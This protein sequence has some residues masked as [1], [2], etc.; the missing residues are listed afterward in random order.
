MHRFIAADVGLRGLV[1]GVQL[2]LALELPL[3]R[4][5]DHRRGKVAVIVLASIHERALRRYKIANGKRAEVLRRSATRLFRPE[6]AAFLPTGKRRF[7]RGEFWDMTVPMLMMPPP[8]T[9]TRFSDWPFAV[10]LI[11]GFW[12]FYAATVVIRAFLGADPWTMLE[13]KLLVV[14][15]GI[16]IN[17]FIYLAISPFTT[18][19]SIRR[20][21][22]VAGISAAVGSLV[23]GGTVVAT[24][25]L[26][27][28]SREEFRFQAREGF[29]VVEQGNQIRIERTAGEPLVLTMPKVHE[30][31][32]MKRV[33]Y[34]LDASIT[35][36]FFYI[37][38]SAFYI[39]NQAQAEVL[40]TQRRLAV[41]ESA[42]QAAQVR[43][44]RY[45]VNPH[46]LF[47]TLNSLSSLVM[48]GRSDRAENMLLALSTFFRTSLSLDPGADVTLAEEIALQRLY[49]DIE[50]A[51]FPD[52][53]QVE[54]AVP[55][56][57]EQARLP[58]LL[59]QPIVENA[60][61][62]GVSKS[63]KA[64]IMRIEAR[65]LDNHRMVVEISNQL[66]NGGKDELPAATHE[67]TGLG[68]TNVCQRLEARFGDHA[69]CR[70]G[71]MHGG[72][73]KVSLTMPVVLNAR[74]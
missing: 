70:F 18:G 60:I 63:R 35:W 9:R 57:L 25:D 72:G 44:L 11:L 50:K 67:G 52:R 47:N 13:N 37:G 16:V 32:L 30:L 46:F 6:A 17:V 2:Q 45:Q 14:G 64:V 51:R 48:T 62:Y 19:S 31:D 42:A 15:I 56:D 27:R 28:E 59:L 68:L 39:A 7:S 36:L 23:L 8:V 34:A 24:E 40:G 21:A 12:L 22:I 29:T 41:A 69:N 61:K 1:A 43:A 4:R 73:F 20:K 10:K 33:R 49:L 26:M 53:L 58:A 55:P 38:W 66:K 71:A 5:R 65:H 54:I 74:D 3:W